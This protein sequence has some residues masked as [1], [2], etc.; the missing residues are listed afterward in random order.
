MRQLSIQ[1]IICKSKPLLSKYDLRHGA[2][3]TCLSDT[4]SRRIVVMV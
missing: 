4:I 2:F 1:V 3:A